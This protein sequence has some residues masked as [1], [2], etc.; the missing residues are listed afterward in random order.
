MKES[1]RVGWAA[2]I[3]WIIW[4]SG[5]ILVFSTDWLI[6]WIIFGIGGVLFML[7]MIFF[8]Q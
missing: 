8:L 1:T 6:S 7:I 5:L 3:T 4:S 2:F